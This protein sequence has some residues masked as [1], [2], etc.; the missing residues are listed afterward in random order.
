VTDLG[1]HAE[2]SAGGLVDGLGRRLEYL[3][4]SVTDR[5]NFRCAYCLPNG[6]PRGS[7]DQPLSVAE[8]ERLVRGFADVGFWKVRLTGGEPT[9]RP[10]VIELVNRVAATPGVRHV[11]LTT[12]G[13]RLRA[14]AKDLAEAGL[15]CLNVSVDSLDPDRFA[16]LTGVSR[17]D[18]VLAGVEAALAA[19]IMRVKVNAVLMAGTGAAEL[20]RFIAWARDLPIS[21][22]FIELMETGSDPEFFR[23]NHVPAAEVERLLAERGFERL[24]RR[25]GDGPAI[26][27]A[28][29]GQ[30]GR[31]GIIAPYRHEFCESCNRLRVSSSGAMKLCLFADREIPLRHLLQSDAQ[32]GELAARVRSSACAKPASHRLREGLVGLVRNLASIGG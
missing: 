23:R 8:I 5:C 14:I 25:P 7:G 24:P 21:V 18:H 32:R 12:N 17:L 10:D 26:D 20:D 13:Y 28:R 27:Y 31:I 11:G 19:R 4:L 6:C 30:R 3:R 29:P 15:T 9:L 1:P 16:A 2:R 22:R